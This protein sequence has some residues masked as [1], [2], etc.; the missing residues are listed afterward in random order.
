M[1]RPA[2]NGGRDRALVHGSKGQQTL[3]QPALDPSPSEFYP[4]AAV[5]AHTGDGPLAQTTKPMRFSATATKAL[6]PGLTRS[7]AAICLLKPP[8]GRPGKGG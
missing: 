5:S 8:P 7:Q 1:G 2:A 4:V 3:Q 6:K